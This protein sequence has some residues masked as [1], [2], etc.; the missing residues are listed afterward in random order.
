M[1][2]IKFE[3]LLEVSTEMLLRALASKREL[4]GKTAREITVMIEE[5]VA[6]GKAEAEGYLE[7]S[8]DEESG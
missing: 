8:S 1:A 6:A 4:N 7:S 5:S 2:K 3:D